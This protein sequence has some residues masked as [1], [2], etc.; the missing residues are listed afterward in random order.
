MVKIACIKISVSLNLLRITRLNVRI[1]T[2]SL[3]HFNRCTVHLED[4]LSVTHQR[5][6]S[7][8]F[9]NLKLV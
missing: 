6:H 8:S 7:I 1:L 2:V 3:E 9:I 4:S 5:M